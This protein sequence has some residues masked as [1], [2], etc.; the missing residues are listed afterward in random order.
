M[1]AFAL[2]HRLTEWL[3]FPPI[4]HSTAD[5]GT[6]IPIPLSTA[7]RLS[8]N[9][10]AVRGV[11]ASSLATASDKNLTREMYQEQVSQNRQWTI[12]RRLKMC[13]TMS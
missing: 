4:I 2:K 3:P 12:S 9:T 13:N 10:L 11:Q 5:R 7:L 1:V 6:G 8:Y